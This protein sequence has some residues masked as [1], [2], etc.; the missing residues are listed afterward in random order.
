MSAGLIPITHN[1]GAAKEDN[2]V[3]EIFR[4]NNLEYALNCLDRAISVWNLDKASK[5]REFAQNFSTENYNKNLKIFIK[6]WIKSNSHLFKKK[7][8]KNSRC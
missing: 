8:I 1:S 3:D 7:E 5:L 2:I 6:N 4:Y